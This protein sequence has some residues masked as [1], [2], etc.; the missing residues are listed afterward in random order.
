[1]S[2][3]QAS[4]AIS[5]SSASVTVANTTTAGSSLYGDQNGTMNNTAS[6]QWAIQAKAAYL[7]GVSQAQII[8]SAASVGVLNTDVLKIIQN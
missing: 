2:D 8:A 1:M 6:G 3:I 7:A 5:P 4:S